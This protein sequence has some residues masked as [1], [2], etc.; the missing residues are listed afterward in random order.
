MFFTPSDHHLIPCPSLLSQ[1][2]NQYTMYIQ[3]VKLMIWWNLQHPNKYSVLSLGCDL[4]VTKYA[5]HVSD[6]HLVL[7]STDILGLRWIHKYYKVYNSSMTGSTNFELLLIN[8]NYFYVTNVR[9]IWNARL[10][11]QNKHYVHTKENSTV[12]N[13]SKN[14]CCSWYV[15]VTN[16][17]NQTWFVRDTHHQWAIH[18]L[19]IR[20]T[21]CLHRWQCQRRL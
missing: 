3:F 6:C 10:Q 12:F 18:I 2:L 17:L 21:V 15:V 19:H 11:P 9:L 14:E 20:G 7:Y 8:V 4:S 1:P 13:L 5:I 16:I